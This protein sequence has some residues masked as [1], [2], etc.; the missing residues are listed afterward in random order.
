[1]ESNK[2]KEFKGRI[3]PTTVQQLLEHT[4]EINQQIEK[5]LVGL[6]NDMNNHR[7]KVAEVT[8]HLDEITEISDE[9]KQFDQFSQSFLQRITVLEQALADYSKSKLI[10]QKK[11]SRLLVW[12][13]INFVI[14]I[15]ALLLI[16][17]R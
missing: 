14:S 17:I 3:A 7:I 8:S 9:I 16:A 11:T 5:V 4:E 13:T 1:M 15:S 2:W 12:A 6:F 10:M